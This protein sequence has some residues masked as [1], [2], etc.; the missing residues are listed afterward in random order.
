MSLKTLRIIV[1]VCLNTVLFP[2]SWNELSDTLE[3]NG[4]EINPQ[5]PSPRPIG[6]LSITG[7]IARKGKTIVIFDSSGMQIQILDISLKSANDELASIIK[8]LD[9]DYKI[10]LYDLVKYYN[11]HSNYIYLSKKNTLKTIGNQCG[12]SKLDDISKILEEKLTPMGLRLCLADTSPNTENWFDIKIEPEVLRNK[13]YSIE[14]VYRNK[15][16]DS[17]KKFIESIE[18]KLDKIITQLEAD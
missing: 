7:E 9:D 10:N 17:Y 14:I 16:I 1:G 3:K 12:F 6:R 13:D 15:K 5:L 4:Y 18:G 11:Y 8:N 2:L